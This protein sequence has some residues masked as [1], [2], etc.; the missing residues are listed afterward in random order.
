MPSSDTEE[1]GGSSGASVDRIESVPL[2]LRWIDDAFTLAP[3]AGGFVTLQA[4]MTKARAAMRVM[5]SAGISVTVAH[6]IVRAC[7]IVLARNPLLAQTVCNYRRLVPGSVDIGL[8]I[9]GETT[10]APVVVLPGIGNVPFAKLVP[11]TIAAIDAAVD[12]ERV[13][14]ANMRKYLWLVPFGFLRRFFLRL[15]NGSL[16]FRR[17]I[18]GTFQVT[19][20]PTC[21]TAVPLLFYTGA[22]LGA[23]G[24]RDRVIAVGGQPVVRPTILLTVAVDHG[25]LDGILAGELV[26]GIK[27]VLEG[28][29]LLQEAQEAASA[30]AAASEDP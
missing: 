10:Y 25:A 30:R 3:R 16:W 4:D 17:R 27:D 29:E 9:A 15:M 23:G 6:V 24:V 26:G 14:L 28:D 19:I 8:S 21:D 12:K 2:G 5:R 18:A 20:M 7:A 22:I 13:D 11:M 1:R